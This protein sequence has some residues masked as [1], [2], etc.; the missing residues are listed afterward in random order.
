MC[1]YCNFRIENGEEL[2]LSD[3]ESLDF[4]FMGKP[5]GAEIVYGEFSRLIDF[6]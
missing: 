3:F 1:L 2:N 4:D 5:G 6:N